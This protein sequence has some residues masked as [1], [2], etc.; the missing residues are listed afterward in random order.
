MAL[1]DVALAVLVA[2]IWGFN[3][4]VIKE[5]LD[6]FPPLLFSG[7]RFLFAAFPT[8]FF[9]PRGNIAWRTI[10]AIG[11]VLGVVKYS[12]LYLGVKAGMPAGLSSLAIQSQVLFR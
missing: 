5:G 1:R 7:L 8:V 11:L 4:V 12:L 9:L 10:F 6:T 2:A 3:F